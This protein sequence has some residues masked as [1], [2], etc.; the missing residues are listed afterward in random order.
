MAC[1]PERKRVRQEPHGQFE[2][3]LESVRWAA[4]IF[5]LFDHYQLIFFQ[6]CNALFVGGHHTVVFRDNNAVEEV[7]DLA[8]NVLDLLL[9]GAALLFT[10]S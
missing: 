6:R 4:L 10:L 8:F 9:Q 7:L 3:I 5:E 1:I 2:Y